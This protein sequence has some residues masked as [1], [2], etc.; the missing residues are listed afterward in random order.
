MFF[1]F[2][3]VG[4]VRIMSYEAERSGNLTNVPSVYFRMSFFF[5]IEILSK[6]LLWWSTLITWVSSCFKASKFFWWTSSCLDK[7]VMIFSFSSISSCIFFLSFARLSSKPTAFDFSDLQASLS[8]SKAASS[9][10]IEVDY[11]AQC[12]QTLYNLF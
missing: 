7:S 5:L 1:F 9:S 10:L 8:S 12:M 2:F 3:D 4:T 6:G 11:W